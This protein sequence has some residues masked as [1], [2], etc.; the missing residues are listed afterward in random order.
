M[1]KSFAQH[2]HLTLKKGQ[3]FH[4]LTQLV[5]NFLL[6]AKLKFIKK[7]KGI[8]H[9]IVHYYGLCWNEE[10][11]L[12]FMFDY[13]GQFVDKFTI[14]D[15]YSTDQSEKI[16]NSHSNAKIIKFSMNN[17]INDFVYQDIKNNCWK[18]SRGK[19]DYVVVCDMDEF[20]FHPRM[21]DFLNESMKH[22]YSFFHPVGYDMFSEVYPSFQSG[23]Y[24]PFQIDSG[25]QC[26]TYS[27]CILFDP[28][29]IVE[30]NYWVG[31]HE[32][33]PLGVVKMPHKREPLKVLH[34]KNL[35]LDHVLGR[36]RLYRDRLSAKNIENECGVEY[37][38]EEDRISS[39]FWVKYK[40]CCKLD[41]DS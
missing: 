41:Y 23:T 22:H 40:Q 5:I 11:M 20:V 17:Q 13:Y 9:P 24:L 27:K 8:N 34:Y 29:R 18:K 36:V 19:A 6:L 30:I 38:K 14:F 39:E 26:D 15:N 25:Y 10:K 16:I 32:A 12:P 21:K 31:A 28:H 33:R 7:I 2:H 37:L 1:L 4:I 3:N 35:G